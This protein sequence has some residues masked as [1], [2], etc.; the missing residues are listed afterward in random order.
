MNKREILLAK[1]K[2]RKAR[3]SKAS[4]KAK[5][6]KVKSKKYIDMKYPVMSEILSAAEF[7][8]TEF[9]AQKE[10]KARSDDYKKQPMNDQ[11]NEVQPLK[12]KKAPKGVSAPVNMPMN[13]DAKNP[14][15]P[16]A[17]MPMLHSS[18]EY[19]TVNKVLATSFPVE[20]QTPEEDKKEYFPAFV[21]FL[22]S[23]FKNQ[24]QME[25][26]LEVFALDFAQQNNLM[27]DF[28]DDGTFIFHSKNMAPI[29]SDVE[30]MIEPDKTSHPEKC[31]VCMKTK[32]KKD[33]SQEP[34]VC[35]NCQYQMIEPIASKLTPME[36]RYPLV[37]AVSNPYADMDNEELKAQYRAAQK[38]LQEQIKRGNEDSPV[39]QDIRRDLRMI[40]EEAK[41]GGLKLD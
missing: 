18:F 5:S 11:I 32:M 35:K 37:T 24:D 41:S 29:K 12:W 27:L 1:M 30:P 20:F 8:L 19:E 25:Q 23:K 38:M 26:Q 40:Q 6:K 28:K 34:G 7:S 10:A 9:R 4:K 39:I 21:A 16:A 15:E 17:G 22:N 33:M 14:G 3:K 36:A 13:P 2:K 31:E